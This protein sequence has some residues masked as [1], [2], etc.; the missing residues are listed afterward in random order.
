M[1]VATRLKLGHAAMPC[2]EMLTDQGRR[3]WAL[4]NARFHVV[5]LL[6]TWPDASHTV[7]WVHA[8]VH[9][10]KQRFLVNSR[11]HRPHALIR[12]VC[13]EDDVVAFYGT[14]LARSYLGG[15][16]LDEC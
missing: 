3:A 11:S 12:S 4:F 10:G 9:R 14:S 16:H 6:W 2:P 13:E 7:Q 8:L 5:F 15:A 1:D